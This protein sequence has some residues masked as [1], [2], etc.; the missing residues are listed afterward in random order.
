MTEIVDGHRQLPPMERAD[1][2][3]GTRRGIGVSSL[4]RYWTGN[5]SARMP[6]TCRCGRGLARITSVAAKVEDIVV[7]HDDALYPRQCTHPF[8]PF[9]QIV[10]HVR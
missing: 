4:I 8:K 5:I 7:T 3:V 2:M 9:E 10:N 1:W 6:R